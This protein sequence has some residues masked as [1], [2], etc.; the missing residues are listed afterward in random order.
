MLLFEFRIVFKCSNYSQLFG[1][2]L[3]MAFQEHRHYVHFDDVEVDI[4]EIVHETGIT[5]FFC[6]WY[7]V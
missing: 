1:F 6:S 4:L 3:Y 2:I 5:F 7:V